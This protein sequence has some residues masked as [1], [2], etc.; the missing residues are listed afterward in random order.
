MGPPSSDLHLGQEAAHYW[1]LACWVCF[2]PMPSSHKRSTVSTVLSPATVWTPHSICTG[3]ASPPQPHHHRHQHWHCAN[4]HVVKQP[5]HH[6]HAHFAVLRIPLLMLVQRS[7][8]L[9]QQH[10]M[11]Q[12]LSL[13]TCSEAPQQS[14]GESQKTVVCTLWGWFLLSGRFLRRSLS[15]ASSDCLVHF[16][17]CGECHSA[18]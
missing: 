13:S 4:G 12:F 8:K 10:I 5:P 3:T 9:V 18:V 11:L 15:Q 7:P 14:I 1:F 2:M 6:A 17:S 16:I